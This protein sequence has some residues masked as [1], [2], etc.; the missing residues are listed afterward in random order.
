MC[1]GQVDLAG[2]GPKQQPG[3]CPPCTGES[4][5]MTPNQGGTAYAEDCLANGELGL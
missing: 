4:A 1:Y 3:D 2:D 5:I